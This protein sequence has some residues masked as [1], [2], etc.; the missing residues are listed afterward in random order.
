MTQN[1]NISISIFLRYCRKKRHLRFWIFLHFVSQ[2]LYQ[3]WFRLVQHLKMTVWSSVLWKVGV[4]KM[5][6]SWSKNGLLS[7]ASFVFR[8]HR[9]EFATLYLL[10]CG[11]NIYF[12]K[13]AAATLSI[14]KIIP[15]V[16]KVLIQKRS[17]TW[18]R[19]IKIKY[20]WDF[21]QK[22]VWQI[23]KALNYTINALNKS[24]ELWHSIS[25]R[26][27]RPYRSGSV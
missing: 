2:L 1:A 10:L 4:K 6:P 23:E 14:N 8:N 13:N 17:Y 12:T 11:Q 25:G 27:A 20:L 9:A 22:I 21:P 15:M 18:S 16:V 5:T 7:A 26:K 24:S 3:L 19:L